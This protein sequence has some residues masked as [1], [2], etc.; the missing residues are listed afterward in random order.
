MRILITRDEVDMPRIKE[1]YK[2]NYGHDMVE[3]VKK[4]TLEDYKN[5]LVELCD[6]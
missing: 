4:A 2:K 1:C 3:A 6:H 5:L